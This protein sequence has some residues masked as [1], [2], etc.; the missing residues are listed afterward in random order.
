[1]DVAGMHF[2][3]IVLFP[4]SFDCWLVVA[5]L[6]VCSI[7]RKRNNFKVELNLLWPLQQIY[8]CTE[9]WKKIPSHHKL[10]FCGDFY[11][12]FFFLVYARF[13]CCLS[14]MLNL[15]FLSSYWAA[16]LRLMCVYSWVEG[17]N[18]GWLYILVFFFS[19]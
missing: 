9:E 10:F 19:L 15:S 18:H 13:H 14:W 12:F 16:M 2:C 1:M 8:G 17:N 7:K 11:L 6:V 4:P 3:N 5:L